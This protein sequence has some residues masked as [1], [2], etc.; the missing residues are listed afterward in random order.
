MARSV[1]QE[2]DLG[3]SHGWETD[4]YAYLNYN[5][6]YA[7]CEKTLQLMLEDTSW[8]EVFASTANLKLYF[9]HEWLKYTYHEYTCR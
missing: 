9:I 6:E 7:E 4:F 2:S 1:N 3:L 5:S 8:Q